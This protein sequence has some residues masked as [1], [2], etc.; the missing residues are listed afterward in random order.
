MKQVL[1]NIIYKR[2][3]ISFA[4]S[5]EDMQLKKL[6]NN[7]TPGVYLDV[8]CWDPVKASNTYYFSLRNW[9]GI[10]IDPNPELGELYK[11]IRPNDIFI[12]KGVSDKPDS[13]GMTYFM[14]GGNSDSSMNTFDQSFL[15]KGNLMKDVKKTINIPI[16]RLDTIISEHYLSNERLDFFDIDVEGHDLNVLKSNNWEL[17]RPKIVMIETNLNLIK[18]ISSEI[19]QY[20]ES[21]NY[22]L[23][24]K[25]LIQKKLGNLLFIDNNQ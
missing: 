24:G 21:V 1:K 11:K 18:D 12:N 15:E 9:K 8:G 6:I 2:F 4:K 19:T 22:S 5:G 17:Y 3:N 14:L 20:L 13:K 25:M 23:V 7:N 16:V 10:C